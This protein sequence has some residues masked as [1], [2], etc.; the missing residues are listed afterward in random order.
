MQFRKQMYHFLFRK[1]SDL[2]D[3]VLYRSYGMCGG[4]TYVRGPELSNDPLE[5]HMNLVTWALSGEYDEDQP[6]MA[7]WRWSPPR[8]LF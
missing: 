5:S 3:T 2:T 4:E 1:I 8:Y 6:V 7:F